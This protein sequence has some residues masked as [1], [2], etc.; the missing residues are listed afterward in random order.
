MLWQMCTEEA[1][2]EARRA[3]QAA[4]LAEAEVAAQG[5]RRTGRHADAAGGLRTPEQVRHVRWRLARPFC[6]AVFRIFVRAALHA[7]PT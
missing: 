4:W 1:G 5:P 6:F 2:A 7:M 3:V